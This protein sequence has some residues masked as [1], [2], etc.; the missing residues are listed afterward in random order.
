MECTS[1]FQSDGPTTSNY[2]QTQTISSVTETDGEQ[3]APVL[4]LRL[5]K[6]KNPKKVAWKS[7]TID[8]ENLGKKKSKCCC[9]YKKPTVFGESSSESDDECENC[10]GHPEKKKKNRGGNHFSSDKNS[11]EPNT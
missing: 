8:N 11:E 1:G 3:V 5:Q 4:R 9:I 2:S 10:F 7:N 6:P